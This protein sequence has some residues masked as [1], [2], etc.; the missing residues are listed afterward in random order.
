MALNKARGI[1]KIAMLLLALYPILTMYGTLL[2]FGIWLFLLLI[3]YIVLSSKGKSLVYFPDA[4]KMYWGY[5]AIAYLV[6]TRKLGAIVPGGLSFFMFSIMLIFISKLFDLSYYKKYMRILILVAVGLFFAQEAM[7]MTTGSRFVPVLPLGSLTTTMTYGELITRNAMAE[8]SASIFLEPAHFAQFLLL[9]LAVELFT[10]KAKRV[11]NGYSLLIIA[12]LLLMRSGTGIVGLVVLL[13]FRM[14]T[15]LKRLSVGKKIVASVLIVAI[16]GV[17][18]NFYIK[19]EAGGEMFE[20]SQNE[21]TLDEEGHSYARFVVGTLI[22][23][24]L[25]VI[26]KFVGASDEDLLPIAK[27]Y[28]FYADEEENILYMNGWAY[29]LTH[30]GLI[31]LVLLLIVIYKL[32]HNNDELAKGG[33]WLFVAFSFFGQTYGQSLMLIVFIIASHYQYRNKINQFYG[34]EKNTILH[35]RTL[36]VD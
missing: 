18:L 10:D 8:R 24:D 2:N 3:G 1:T 17:A 4:Y 13:L 33:L 35:S 23:N 31:G 12:A 6:L 9:S 11:F 15:Y 19:T 21:L 30:S 28:A 27:K 25:P 32:Y 20:R 22:Y 26:N 14:R 34:K 5:L 29:V 16:A 36:A 7:W